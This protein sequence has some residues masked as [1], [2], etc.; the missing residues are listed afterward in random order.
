MTP[1]VYVFHEAHQDMLKQPI[2]DHRTFAVVVTTRID[3][4]LMAAPVNKLTIRIGIAR[5]SPKDQFTRQ[6]GR[7]IAMTRAL[8]TRSGDG[9]KEFIKAGEV[10][11]AYDLR[12]SKYLMA[13]I[14][15]YL[16]DELRFRA[17]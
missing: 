2:K 13:A 14:L 16:Q 17:R 12:E 3:P 4:N 15:R 5:C 1:Q 11:S 6:T 7:G 10:Q 8:L 9:P